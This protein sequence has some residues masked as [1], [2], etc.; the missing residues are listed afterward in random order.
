MQLGVLIV[1]DE[2]GIRRSLTRI[3]KE[4]GYTVQT[5]PDGEE[6]VKKFQQDSHS[7]DIVICDLIMPG[8]DGIKTIEEINKIHQKVTKIILTGYCTLENSIK[9]IDAG[10]DGFITKPFEN[11][12]FTWKVKE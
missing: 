8:L 9:S 6:A 1:D 4:E 3:L 5:A 10:I 2:D 11:K 12:E 7:F